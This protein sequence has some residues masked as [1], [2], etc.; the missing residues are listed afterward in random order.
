MLEPVSGFETLEVWKEARL[1]RKMIITLCREFPADEKFR[2]IDQVKRSS[3]SV[4][5]NISEG[6]GRFHYLDNIKF[7]R[8]ARGSLNETLDH[9]TVAFDESYISL[10]SFTVR[11]MQYEKV[12]RLL[13]GYIG[14][15]KKQK[16]TQ[17]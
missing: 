1:F 13:N 14:Y 2:L 15:L 6:Y 11:K 10:E 4:T 12:L 7:C 17:Q 8:D 16:L 9:L 3:R 5:A